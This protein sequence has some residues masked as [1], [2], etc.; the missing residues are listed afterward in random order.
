MRNE[1]SNRVPDPAEF[2]A[3]L[4]NVKPNRISA[5]TKSHPAT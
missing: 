5:I 4:Q 3:I 2:R 1:R